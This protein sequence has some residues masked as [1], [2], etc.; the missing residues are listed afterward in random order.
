[1]FSIGDESIYD[2][3]EGATDSHPITL[4][5]NTVDEVRDLL[6]CLY[7]LP[8]E[9]YA[10]GSSRSSVQKLINIARLSNKY[11]FI[12]TEQWTLRLLTELYTDAPLTTTVTSSAPR[13]LPRLPTSPQS[14]STS[15]PEPPEKQTQLLVQCTEIAA[16][17]GY[18]PLLS[19]V[20]A[21]WKTRI[22]ERKDLALAISVFSR[23]APYKSKL[24]PKQRA[25]PQLPVRRQ[26]LPA[27]QG[28][29]PSQ[30]SSTPRP[31]PDRDRS[32]LEDLQGQAYY[33]LML[34]G[35]TAWTDPLLTRDHRIRLLSGYHEITKLAD[36]LPLRPPTF[37]HVNEVS[38]ERRPHS[39]PEGSQS[40]SG[41]S[42]NSSSEE[43]YA[44]DWCYDA[45]GCKEAWRG[46]W[47]NITR[48]DSDF[49]A[50]ASILFQA[51]NLSLTHHPGSPSET[52]TSAPQDSLR[53]NL[54]SR[55]S[56]RADYQWKMML[57]I[58]VIE[59]VLSHSIPR[60]GLVPDELNEA[61]ARRALDATRRQLDKFRK[62]M[63]D[64]FVDVE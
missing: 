35:R 4:H 62:G 15:L 31:I 64:Y 30:R 38:S 5:G 9:I 21:K 1:M 22:G 60:E 26:T 58:S 44:F 46:L 50:L 52:D 25:E 45:V 37:A 6:W 29:R 63:M 17:T 43:E 33:A 10:L 59:G 48:P 14:H 13:P 7:A 49:A 40:G 39:H 53:I 28:P 54:N 55:G 57:A 18:K 12:Q 42:G 3:P 27:V 47:Y 23:L 2:P 56:E 34:Q 16:L 19:I 32:D 11:H 61:C 51:S 41:G 36:A 24:K 20:R 8:H